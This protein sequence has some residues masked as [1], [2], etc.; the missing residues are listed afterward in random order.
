MQIR[1]TVDLSSE[2]RQAVFLDGLDL[3]LKLGLL[4]DDQVRLLCAEM[5]AERVQFPDPMVADEPI[6]DFAP[7]E[8]ARGQ[9]RTPA[10]RTTPSRITTSQVTTAQTPV[11][12]P[13]R[14]PQP[15]SQAARL[16]QSFFAE[17][18]VA[19][20]LFLGMFLVVVSSGVLA[21][22]QWQY[23]SPLGQYCV[24]FAYT[25][26]LW[27]SSLW[28]ARQA[29]LPL[30]AQ[31]LGLT[32]LLLIPINVW[33]MDSIGVAQNPLGLGIGLVLLV[34]LGGI[35]WLTLQ[36]LYRQHPEQSAPVI[37]LT[38][39]GL[40]GLHLGWGV[41]MMPVLAPYGGAIA[42]T[43]SWFYRVR[44]KRH[45]A[46]ASPTDSA[47][48]T[49]VPSRSHPNI[50]IT[51]A[52]LLL[53]FR[54]LVVAHVPPHQL[55]LAL[56]LVGWLLCWLVRQDHRHPTWG[57]LGASLL[58]LGWAVS[59]GQMPPLQAVAVSLLV[60]ELLWE[61]L[62]RR[63][64]VAALVALLVVGLQ[65]YWLSG[66]IIP[67]AW[68]EAILANLSLWS[69]DTL[70]SQN[71]SSVGVF[72]Y[73]WLMLLFAQRLRGWQQSRLAR[74]ADGMALGLGTILV[75]AGAINSL[76]RMLTLILATVTL[77]VVVRLRAQVPVFLIYLTHIA[78][79]LAGLAGIDFIW[80][81]L[82]SLI[83]ARIL[84]G[85]MVAEWGFSLLPPW[86]R[87][88]QSAWPI[89]LGLAAIAFFTLLPN[90]GGHAPLIWL[91][92][93][94]VLTAL[95]TRPQAH[96]PRVAA[97]L[98]VPTL[99]MQLGLLNSSAAVLIT[100]GVG[101]LLMLINT[102]RLQQL[103]AALI[104]VGFAVTTGVLG[105][106]EYRG[107]DLAVN[108]LVLFIAVLTCGLTL[109]QAILRRRT[110]QLSALYAEAVH[111]W[112]ILL[113]VLTLYGLSW[114]VGLAWL[115]SFTATWG[116][117]VTMLALKRLCLAA[118][119]MVG[120]IAYRIWVRP[121][122]WG[123]WGWAWAVE[124]LVFG[125]GVL[126]DVP[127]DAF[128]WIQMGLGLGALAM[129]DAGVRFRS[130]V[131]LSSWHG[132]PLV[133]GL[134]G[135]LL[136]HTDFD[137]LTGLYT[138][139]LA[140]ICIGVGRRAAQLEVLAYLGV[141]LLSVGAY[142]ALI[143][144]LSLAESGSAGDGFVILG[145]L[146]AAIAVLERSMA[147][148]LG[149]W[150]RLP[151]PS[152]HTLAHVH[153]VIAGLWAIGA[154][155][156]P[157]SNSGAYGWLGL[158]G[159][160]TV[161]A[162]VL[163]NQRLM[164][165]VTPDQARIWTYLGIVGI[166][167]DLTFGLVRWMSWADL[168]GWAAAIA[169]LVAL[170]FYAVPWSRLGW[171]L[172]PWRQSG[173]LLPAVVIALTASTIGIPSLLLAAAFYAGVAKVEMRSRLSY[174]SLLLLDWGVLR[175]LDSLNQ[176]SAL[177]VSSLAGVSLLYIAQVDP[178][179]QPDSAR[180]QRH[181]L[182]ILAVG[183]ICLTLA[184]QAEVAMGNVAL[185]YRLTLLGVGFGLGLAGI[186]LRVRAFLYIGTLS[187][188]AQV[189][190]ILWLFIASNALIL[191]AV[192]I[193]LGLAFIW[194]AATFESRRSQVGG[195]MQTWSDSLDAWD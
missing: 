128:I 120:T 126:H 136:G 114:G 117:V 137:A 49:P 56:G 152:L 106:N 185:F 107:D 68:K 44:T 167:A 32:T 109:L 125:G 18:G 112:S 16:M 164:T 37:S 24:L 3:W 88:R 65:T 22:S 123:F 187:F 92:T 53:F 115:D 130:G 75:T 132:I 82:D 51:L 11:P 60:M 150:L 21:A 30:T 153:G 39:L 5:L 170:I 135:L 127:F 69:P 139:A 78:G 59:Q 182:R 122:N 192:G 175:Y 47:A 90:W 124:L 96:Q 131:Y 48:P 111:T 158:V 91:T 33:L 188:V 193:V 14:P 20:L 46:I 141:I 97:W 45:L 86:P 34:L 121:T 186:S 163:G 87:W 55:G 159:I 58:A 181:W 103:L 54:S 43:I 17:V 84:L 61:W 38:Y 102:Y 77:A 76:T 129:G 74:L 99:F 180:N 41:A 183:L 169:A 191:W 9:S 10:P 178:A 67:D 100:F 118:G 85:L 165:E 110:Q 194:I 166:L 105:F 149:V 71:L 157:I 177:W 116:A 72:P 143:Y 146:A 168:G 25:A 140:A 26:V 190:R 144:Q 13:P 73:L 101:T 119:L 108:E 195:L 155:R 31:V 148:W 50:A 133:F 134:L 172:S 154:L 179:L 176:L 174:V 15:P 147:R 173:E 36:M 7:L 113:T 6:T 2:R 23:F 160:L 19:W 151:A 64:Q 189:L 171:L 95:A 162:L 145:M 29:S 40:S 89:G 62:R 27:G 12:S 94:V 156:E 104:T 28:A 8:P 161:Y 142:E 52:L 1:F 80:P 35:G 138:V 184:Y 98:V 63:W 79:V 57:W 70:S 81:D 66:D 83:W 42:T 93:P 4:S